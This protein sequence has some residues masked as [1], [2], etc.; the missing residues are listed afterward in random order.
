MPSTYF[1]N[2]VKQMV[3]A[4]SAATDSTA[5]S[6]PFDN[7]IPQDTEGKEYFTAS[8]T[9]TSSTSTLV[10][11]VYVPVVT[12][13]TDAE[14][15]GALFQDSTAN[16]IAVAT[17][18]R[19]QNTTSQFRLLYYMTSGT[20]SSTTFKFRFGSNT[21]TAYLG[22]DTGGTGLYNGICVSNMTITEYE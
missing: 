5:T 13:S 12:V 15:I 1:Q 16:A 22:T 2:R 9:P 20:T 14:W 3:F 17:S 7:T 19:I 10:I 18:C 21:G 6:I 8:I 4:S 11:E